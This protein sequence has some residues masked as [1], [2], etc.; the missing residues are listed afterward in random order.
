[1]LLKIPKLLQPDLRNIHNVDRL[2]NRRVGIRSL[3]VRTKRKDECDQILV[4]R[5]EPNQLWRDLGHDGRR[6]A[7]RGLVC[8]NGFGVQTCYFK[9]IYRDT[10]FVA[11]ACPLRI[12]VWSTRF[13]LHNGPRHTRRRDCS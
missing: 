5:E 3:D 11:T 2:R 4:Q 12:L 8:A 13:E 9:D 10:T 6:F 1:M 7:G